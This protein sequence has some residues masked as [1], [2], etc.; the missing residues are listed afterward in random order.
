MGLTFH[1]VTDIKQKYCLYISPTV[2]KRLHCVFH[3]SQLLVSFSTDPAVVP[4]YE[5][6]FPLERDIQ[7]FISRAFF[8]KDKSY[9][10]G[11]HG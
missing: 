1:S 9:L 7:L 10:F 5:S 11:V 4:L 8:L 2:S 3:I 6:V